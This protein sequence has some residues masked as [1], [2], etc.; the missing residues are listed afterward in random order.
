ML[1]K[2]FYFFLEFTC[3][4][5]ISKVLLITINVNYEIIRQPAKA[6]QLFWL[7][8]WK[9]AYYTIDKT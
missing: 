8:L 9:A 5:V 6:K 1:C 2:S 3:R 7:P 4:V